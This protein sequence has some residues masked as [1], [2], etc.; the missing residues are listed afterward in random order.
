MK[1]RSDDT[2]S[3]TDQGNG[4]GGPVTTPTTTPATTTP[5]TEAKP[6]KE[7]TAAEVLAF[8]PF[9]PPK[10]GEA[11]AGD[12]PKATPTTTTPTEKKGAVETGKP[13]AKPG[14]TGTPAAP[15]PVTTKVEPSALERT[16]QEQAQTI[17]ELTSRSA[18]DAKPAAPEETKPR[19]NL[20]VPPQMIE[21]MASEDPKERG[22]AVQALV[23]GVANHV[24]DAVQANFQKE[25]LPVL[26]QV[27]Q[28]ELDGRNKV[29]A[30]YSDMSSAHPALVKPEVVPLV[31]N[32]AAMVG[33]ERHAA[34]KSLEWSAEF[35]DEIAERVY[36]FLPG[37]R[38]PATDPNAVDP[39]KPNGKTPTFST[40]GGSR[41]AAVPVN[42]FMEI[43]NVGR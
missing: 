15:A 13:A 37:L 18:A 2:G 38:P 20:G 42:E 23:N 8:D 9:A 11:P 16:I 21:A 31:Q 7:P 17:R 32:I 28:R 25:V 22:M 40:G 10:S 19:F 6:A 24:W 30:I 33:T 39:N 5:A 34:G 3:V 29:Q 41:P 43:V 36:S 4:G 14:D 1:L 12:S 26:T 27:V 35:R